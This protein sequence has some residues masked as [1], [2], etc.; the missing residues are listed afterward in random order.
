VFCNS[1]LDFRRRHKQCIAGEQRQHAVHLVTLAGRGF[2]QVKPGYRYFDTI[3]P[4]TV[5]IVCDPA[6]RK[7]P[8]PDQHAV[9]GC[10]TDGK[11]TIRQVCHDPAMGQHVA[12]VT[13][14]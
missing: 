4:D 5:F 10:S 12:K 6:N 3:G 1:P 7:Y 14:G 13:H 2:L 9:S 11:F 8:F